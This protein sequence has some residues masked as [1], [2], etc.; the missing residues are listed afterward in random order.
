VRPIVIL[1]TGNTLPGIDAARGDFEAWIE[2]GLGWPAEDLLVIEVH[3]DEPL[4]APDAVAGVVVTGSPAMV[5]DREPWSVRSGEWLASLVE[6]GTP[7]LGICYGHQLL[8]DVL[9]GEVGPN[10]RGR[11]IGTVCVELF[12]HRDDPL[13][14]GLGDRLPAHTTHLETVLRLPDGARAMARSALDD[15]H[16]FRVGAHAWGVQFHPEFDADVMRRYVDA[17]REPILAEGLDADRIRA[18]VEDTPA[19]AALLP[20][21][22][23]LVRQRELARDGPSGGPP[24]TGK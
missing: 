3:R 9:G 13:L 5:S 11:E 4:P 12:D 19:S 2:P 15:N 18:A 20:R 23:E 16:V 21:F 6:L 8:A 14:A 7:I 1:K 24:S 22:G 10:P 17:R